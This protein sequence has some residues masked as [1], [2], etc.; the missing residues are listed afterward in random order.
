M[1][2]LFKKNWFI[3]PQKYKLLSAY[4]HVKLDSKYSMMHKT[5][6]PT[7]NINLEKNLDQLWGELAPN[8]R[9]EIR[10]SK[11]NDIIE[12]SVNLK[13]DDCINLYNKFSYLNG[14]NKV[15]YES[16]IIITSAACD[17]DII[18]IHIYRVDSNN[19]IARLIGSTNNIDTG[20]SKKI[21][22]STNR[23]LHWNDICHFK[24]IGIKIYDLGGVPDSDQYS[25]KQLNIARYK[26]SFGG[27]KVD[28]YNYVGYLYIIIKWMSK[29]FR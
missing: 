27:E 20:I 2:S 4:Y 12:F 29:F 15:K 16:N 26:K 23:A 7:I 1:H 22:A 11:K 21:V 24:S 28:Y 18:T 13:I 6:F 5:R 19:T 9:N 8:T 25:E 10:Q 3:K 14:F 17:L